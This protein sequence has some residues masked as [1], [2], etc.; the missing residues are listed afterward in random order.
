[1]LQAEETAR[2]EQGRESSLIEEARVQTVETLIAEDALE[3]HGGTVDL[4][5]LLVE[6]SWWSPVEG[7]GAEARA[8]RRRVSASRLQFAVPGLASSL[9]ISA[10]VGYGSKEE[11]TLCTS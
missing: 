8:G 3:P 10:M 6:D 11:L 1:M 2:V 7:E 5:E 9:L 4:G